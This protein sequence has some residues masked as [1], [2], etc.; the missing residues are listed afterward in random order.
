[1][2]CGQSLLRDKGWQDTRSKV[3]LSLSRWSLVLDWEKSLGQGGSKPL[4][5]FWIPYRRSPGNYQGMEGTTGRHKKWWWINMEICDVVCNPGWS[6][7]EKTIYINPR[8]NLL[9][10][11]LY[12]SRVPSCTSFPEWLSSY[13]YTCHLAKIHQMFSKTQ[14][15]YY[16]G[17]VH[18][19]LCL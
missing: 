15:G 8:S 1:M 5:G 11:A 17:P 2:P 6:C 14:F 7:S 19:V 3:T 4:A 9:F 10:K 13:C 18:K 12:F 16:R